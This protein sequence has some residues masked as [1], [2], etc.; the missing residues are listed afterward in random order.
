MLSSLVTLPFEFLQ[1]SAL[2]LRD[3]RLLLYS[4]TPCLLGCLAFVLFLWL[5]AG[6]QEAALSL[7]PWPL[8]GWLATV[9]G[10]LWVLLAAIPLAGLLGYLCTLVLGSVFLELLAER[11]LEL[12]GV[13]LSSPSTWGELLADF[14]KALLAS[15]FRL[16]YVGLLALLALA[17]SFFPP[18]LLI[19]L[20]LNAFIVGWD[21]LDTPQSKF[22]LSFGER[23]RQLFQH[24]LDVLSLGF[25][26]SLSFLVPF[27]AALLL[28]AATVVATRRVA[29]WQ[30][31]EK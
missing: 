27:L 2:I 28:P 15:L 18:L 9:L 11:V 12:D 24:K 6:Q 1:A 19:P 31:A 14:C 29:G 21:L 8:P 10:W 3:K 5:L 4:L 22:L 26:F 25:F 13:R 30:E 17:L 23:R 16:L 20:T 7:L